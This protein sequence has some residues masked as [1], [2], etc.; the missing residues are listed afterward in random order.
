MSDG[1]S[2]EP[3]PIEGR[4]SA[5]KRVLLGG[6]C[7]YNEGAFSL[8][9]RIRDLS[10]GGARI[11][12]PAG[13]VL[14]TRVILIDMRDRVA[15]EAEVVWFKPAECGLKFLNKF[16]LRSELPPAMAYLKRF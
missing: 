10:E 11:T 3:P 14:P 12:L 13:Q 2:P 9:C 4:K 6:K 8:D 15:Y 1:S 16:S 7:V 5:R